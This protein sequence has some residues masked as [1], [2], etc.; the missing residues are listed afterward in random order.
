M[1]PYRRWRN[2]GVHRALISVAFACITVAGCSDA[3]PRR[4]ASGAVGADAP[5]LPRVGPI[6][7]ERYTGPQGRVGQFVVKCTYSH[8][9][10]N[11]PI[12]H[13]G[14]AGHSHRHDFY[15]AV[16]TDAT[17]T[18]EQ[19]ETQKTTC[20]KE[21]DTA[22]YWHPSLYDGNTVIRPRSI[23]AYYRAAPG[24]NPE[25][26]QPFPFGLAMIAGDAAA[27]EAQ[28]GGAVGWVCGAST[29]LQ[30]GPPDCPASAPLH[31]ELTFPDC[32]DGRH[33]DSAD[34][35]SHVAYSAR[36]KCPVSRPVPM[37]QLMMSV[38]F[39]VSG[40]GH[41]LR[42]ASGSVVTAHGDFL[43]AWTPAGLAREVNA[44]IHRDVVCELAS[45]RE[46]E[47]L[48]QVR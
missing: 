31:L 30:A 36:G 37:P 3:A 19:L 47:A 44:C 34:H 17:S 38:N 40:T 42:L 28:I 16:G 45:N 8:S 43:N 29:D 25:S 14:H 21:F 32:W 11:D 18:P 22:A 5:E 9:G 26:V 6:G 23:A 4:V 20:D 39:G 46:E 41:D 35:R 2:V 13:F 24:V 7:P 15:G 12:V 10:E 27:T 33:L 48:F 1:T